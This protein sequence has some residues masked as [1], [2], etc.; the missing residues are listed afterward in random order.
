MKYFMSRFIGSHKCSFIYSTTGHW[1]SP[2]TVKLGI[3]KRVEL[4]YSEIEEIVDMFP[5][6]Y[7]DTVEVNKAA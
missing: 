5:P 3:E 6:S 4:S 7:R 2:A 1:V